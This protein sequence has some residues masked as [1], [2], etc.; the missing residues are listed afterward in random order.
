MLYKLSPIQKHQ[1]QIWPCHKSGQGEPK[2]IIWKKPQGMG[3]QTL[4][5]NSGYILKLLLFP[6]FCTSSRMIPFASLFYMIFCFISYMY[7]KPQGKKRQ[8]LA[9]MFFDASRKDITLITGCTFQKN[10]SALWFYVH[11]FMFLY[12]YIALGQGQTTHLGQNFYVNRKTSSLW[13]FV[14]SL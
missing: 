4:G 7:I 9:T 11:F 2:V 3:I 10:S 14:A 6:S 1:E 5:T 13:S 8:P 12:M